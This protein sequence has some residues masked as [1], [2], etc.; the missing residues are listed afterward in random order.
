MSVSTL[1]F[2]EKTD[3]L[4]AN[5]F[6]TRRR[7]RGKLQAHDGKEA[8]KRDHDL[9]TNGHKEK[10]VCNLKTGAR[11]TEEYINVADHDQQS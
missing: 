9:R 11:E 6:P 3:H 5:S 7:N 10:P 1:I 8:E 4:S 2:N